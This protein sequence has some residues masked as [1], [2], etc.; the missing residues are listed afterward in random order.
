MRVPRS[1]SNEINHIEAL[2]STIRINDATVLSREA[3]HENVYS[4]NGGQGSAPV[5]ILFFCYDQNIARSFPRFSKII[6][7]QGTVASLA[8][9]ISHRLPLNSLCLFL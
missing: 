2:A 6:L 3:D 4:S 7:Y 5:G 1:Q 8:F 9:L